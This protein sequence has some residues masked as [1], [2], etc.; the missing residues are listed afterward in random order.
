VL[1]A[2]GHAASQVASK[3]EPHALRAVA[4]ISAPLQS[5]PRTFRDTLG[6]L[7]VYTLFVGLTLLVYVCFIHKAPS[8]EPAH[9]GVKLADRNDRK[10]AAGEVVRSDEHGHEGEHGD[11]HADAA[12]ADDGHGKADAGKDAHGKKDD[13]HGAKKDDGKKGGT[14]APAPPKLPTP[15]FKA[16]PG[17]AKKDAKPEAKK[18]AGHGGGH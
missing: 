17:A 3:A 6:W 13:G 14:K 12:H 5:R 10:G 7:G 18:D 11:G 16:G 2:A 8:P 1:H 9:P 15:Q 4:T